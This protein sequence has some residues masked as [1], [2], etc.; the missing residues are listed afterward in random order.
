MKA[1]FNDT[2]VDDLS[3]SLDDRG[4]QYGDGLFETIIVQESEP[5]LLE[6]HLLRLKKGM[7]IL[8]M[9]APSYFSQDF[10]HQKIIALARLNQLDSAVVNLMVWRK[11]GG[12]Y[13][14]VGREVN[15]L[16]KCRVYQDREKRLKKV[17]ICK[18]IKNAYQVFSPYKSD[19]L[20]YVLAGIEKRDRQL[21]DLIILDVHGHISE[22]VDKNIFWYDGNSYFTP[23]IDTGCIA[24][25]MREELIS[26][27]A[28]QGKEVIEGE[29]VPEVLENAESIFACNASGI[30]L[31]KE[32]IF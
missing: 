24:G 5:L 11:P 3:L 30:Y 14:P 15:W 17:G 22:T 27:F 10:V 4:L 6:R 8:Q 26:E 7:S 31:I 16:M 25:V 13:A 28:S 23:S 21:D 18:S 29:F 32:V 9:E 12:L 1:I 20:K 2:E 19:S